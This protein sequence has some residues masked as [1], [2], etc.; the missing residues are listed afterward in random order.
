MELQ[1]PSTPAQEKEGTLQCP[2]LSLALK[3]HPEQT[4]AAHHVLPGKGKHRSQ[5]H[6]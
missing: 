3:P 6:S 5:H 4:E 2:H 1:T